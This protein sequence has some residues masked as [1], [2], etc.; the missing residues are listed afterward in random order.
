MPRH[1]IRVTLNCH[2]PDFTE[3]EAWEFVTEHMSVGT[4]P[5]TAA[6]RNMPGLGK[7]FLGD[8]EGLHVDWEVT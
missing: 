1:V 6:V 4:D 7:V 3:D 2:H 5:Y 8:G